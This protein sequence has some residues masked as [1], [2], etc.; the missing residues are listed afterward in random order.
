MQYL[1]SFII[2]A[3]TFIGLYNY[4]PLD[5]VAFNQ[6][7]RTFGSTITTIQGSDTLSASR[8]V[9]N[10]N[11]SNLNDTKIENSTTSVKS[12]TTLSSLSSIGTILTGIWNGSTI[13]VAY[14]GTG[15]TTLS[16]NQILLG[17]G[18]GILKTVTGFGSSGEVL[19]SNG[20]GTAPTW[21]SASVNQNVAYTWTAHHI[22][23]TLFATAASSTN[24]TTTNLTVTGNAIFT[25]EQWNEKL[26]LDA[27]TPSITSST[28]STTIFSF[29]VP[30]NTLSTG[31]AVICDYLAKGTN[32]S[33]Q[34]IAYDVSYG[35][36]STTIRFQ[37]PPGGASAF[38]A[39]GGAKIILAA[40]GATNDQTLT[41]QAY[42]TSTITVNR[43]IA[44]DSTTD[45]NITFI[46]KVTDTSMAISQGVVTCELFR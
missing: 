27:T 17:N 21:Q 13:T 33:G 8:S 38:E 12:I 43:D 25:N 40:D 19:V 7:V 46:A 34:F 26:Y 45:K 14:G 37:G 11:F 35:N 41:M 22:F 39:A 31:N 5:L 4:L 15:S 44:I 28:A 20:A 18:T 6:G 3:I 1:A 23:S 2:S 9:I 42:S 29:S 24:A 32:L 10:T 30:A 36:A 16:S